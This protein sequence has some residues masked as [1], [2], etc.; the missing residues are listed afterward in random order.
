MR[1]L[2]LSGRVS[3]IGSTPV[4]AKNS[5]VGKLGACTYR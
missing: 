3:L 1:R 5:E 2:V 4:A